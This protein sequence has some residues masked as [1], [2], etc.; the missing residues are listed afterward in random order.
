MRATLQA[1]RVHRKADPSR[2]IPKVTSFQINPFWSLS[3]GLYQTSHWDEKVWSRIWAKGVTGRDG[4]QNQICLSIFSLSFSLFDHQILLSLPAFK[5]GR[6]LWTIA[7]SQV[8]R[9]ITAQSA[10]KNW[11]EWFTC[12]KHPLFWFNLFDQYNESSLGAFKK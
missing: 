4:D 12:S 2:M 3:L 7:V 6:S 5:A 1:F 8:L 9:E 10:L 11:K